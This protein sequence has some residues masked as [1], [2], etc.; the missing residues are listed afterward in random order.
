MFQKCYTTKSSTKIRD[1][2]TFFKKLL[3]LKFWREKFLQMADFSSGPCSKTFLEQNWLYKIFAYIDFLKELLKFKLAPLL[4]LSSWAKF[5]ND[6]FGWK[7]FFLQGPL[8]ALASWLKFVDR[9]RFSSPS[10]MKEGE[11]EC[12][13][14][15]M[16]SWDNM[17]RYRNDVIF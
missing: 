17:L 3:K 5:P 6:K 15:W 10:A 12:H 2:W 8:I 9:S 1:L 7:R 16:I 11:E 14:K 13:K 4:Q